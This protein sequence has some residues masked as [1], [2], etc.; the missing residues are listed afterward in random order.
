MRCRPTLTCGVLTAVIVSR[1]TRPTALAVIR[2]FSLLAITLTCR[3]LD[4][5]GHQSRLT[6]HAGSEGAVLAVNI[7]TCVAALTV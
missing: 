6:R 4:G 7:G 1:Q 5:D 3:G 2:Q